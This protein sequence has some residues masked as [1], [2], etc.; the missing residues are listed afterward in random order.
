[1][2]NNKIKPIKLL[3]KPFGCSICHMDFAQAKS[4][5]NHV[6][7]FHFK[8]LEKSRIQKKEE[9]TENLSTK[10]KE[11]DSSVKE[12]CPS[13][14]TNSENNREKDLESQN[15]NLE[16]LVQNLVESRNKS[17]NESLKKKLY[18]C[19]ICGKQFNR[20]EVLKTHKRTHTGEKPFSCKF[21]NKSF[22]QP[23]ILK[24]HEWIHTGEKPYSC[25]HCNQKFRHKD[26][27]ENHERALHTS[28]KPFE[29]KN[30]NK[31]FTTS[32]KL[33][34]HKKLI[35]RFR[36][37]FSKHNHLRIF[38]LLFFQESFNNK[39]KSTGGERFT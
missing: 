13:D 39:T 10:N 33:F 35:K 29:C 28:E 27:C 5:A 4:L 15:C 1:M 34:H 3:E 11:P 36:S 22:I 23:S 9:N 14:N 2:F 16:F 38:F 17:T 32:N 7:T 31:R 19:T 6:E 26:S 20:P 25:K 37:L 24:R 12:T 18:K 8:G 21:C 30:C